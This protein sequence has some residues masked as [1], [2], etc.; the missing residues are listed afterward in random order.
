MKIRYS[1][2][3]ESHFRF[4]KPEMNFFEL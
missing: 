2:D 4:T 1:L 3:K